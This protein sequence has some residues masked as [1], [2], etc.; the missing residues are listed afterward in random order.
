MQLEKEDREQEMENGTET[1]ENDVASP[2]SIVQPIDISRMPL[3]LFSCAMRG[4]FS[5]LSIFSLL[6]IALK[7]LRELV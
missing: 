2:P 5:Y 3:L 1:I 4:I 7:S 6:N